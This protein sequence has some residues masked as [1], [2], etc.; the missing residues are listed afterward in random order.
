MTQKELDWARLSLGLTAGAI[1]KKSSAHSAKKTLK[2]RLSKQSIM[3]NKPNKRR[4]VPTPDS[5]HHNLLLA[6]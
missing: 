6:T 1:K 2:E 5:L 4:Y 3:K